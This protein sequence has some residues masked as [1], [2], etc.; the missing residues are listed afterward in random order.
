MKI[1]VELE[2][3]KARIDPLLT[4]ERGKGALGE[5]ELA[6]VSEIV[7]GVTRWRRTLDTVIEAASD[8]PLARIGPLVMALLR[9][10]LYQAAMMSSAPAY[11]A[12]NE[13]VAL[14]K[15]RPRSRPA[16][17]F[18]NAVLRRAVRA[19][20]GRSLRETAEELLPAGLPG[21][22]RLGRIHSFPDWL[23]ER[24][25]KNFGP[26]AA[27][28]IMEE[29]NRRG[30]VFFR[31]NTL[32]T[33]PDDFEKSFAGWG[34]EAERVPWARDVYKL[35][36]GRI[37]PESAPVRLGLI[38]P[39]DASSAVAASLLGPA[40]GEN[41]ADACCGVGVKSGAFAQWMENNGMLFSMDIS[42][43]KFA[44]GA[45]NMNRLGVVNSRRVLADAAAPWPA[46]RPF[47]KIFLDAPCSAT[48]TLRRRPEGKWNKDPGLISAMA[49]LQWDMIN[50]AADSL[51]PGGALVYSVCS[52][53][54]EEGVMIVERLLEKRTDFKRDIRPGGGTEAAGFF[55]ERGD[56]FT[57]P[58]DGGM[59]GFYA[60]R[61]V[62]AR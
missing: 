21:H 47:G 8:R 31:L 12:V 9:M 38:Q 22:A 55:D 53:E 34:L 20:A 14:A 42:R 15:S 10:G 49:G 40:P 44:E 24:W 62:R 52:I 43:A 30:P 29:S 36:G 37:T 11:A 45:R 56:F 13:T 19:A 61:L 4:A 54:P 46:K 48:G 59:D 2:R 16:A 50:H 27:E 17:G 23:A 28:R 58:G 51:A 6:F 41:V 57:L 5:R 1:L 7:Y 3:R 26:G 35:T 33:R 18:V 60:A 25:I 39:Q 32:K